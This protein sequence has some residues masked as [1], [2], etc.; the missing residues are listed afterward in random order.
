MT[1]PSFASAQQR[2]L[3]RRRLREAEA[4]TRLSSQ[5]AAHASNPLSRLPSPFDTFGFKTLQIWDQIKGP[6]GTR[7]AFRVGQVDADL[8]DEELLEMLK[9]QVGD[10]LKMFGSHLRDDWAAEILLGL[11]AVLFKLS[12]WDHNASYGAALQNLRYVDA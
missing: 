10:G 5:V 12:M 1:S 6:S 3:T 7:P 2:I 4:R 8:L 9:V 11:S